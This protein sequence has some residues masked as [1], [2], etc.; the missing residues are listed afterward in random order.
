MAFQN[1]ISALKKLID[2]SDIAFLT[3]TFYTW[4]YALYKILCEYTNIIYCYTLPNFT[5]YA[6]LDNIT[7]KKM[8]N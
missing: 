4:C 2:S 3:R 6:N 8:K 7:H 1:L 5:E